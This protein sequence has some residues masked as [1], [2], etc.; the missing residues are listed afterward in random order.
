MGRDGRR[1]TL[2]LRNSRINV[3]WDRKYRTHLGMEI[4]QG[5]A[6]V[7]SRKRMLL[8]HRGEAPRAE[9]FIHCL[10]VQVA[11]VPG[12]SSCKVDLSFPALQAPASPCYG[13]VLPLEEG[14]GSAE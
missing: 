9:E 3:Q 10:L 1:N 7:G 12:V 14:G 6:G 4:N 2:N 11:R 5:G 8:S 13:G